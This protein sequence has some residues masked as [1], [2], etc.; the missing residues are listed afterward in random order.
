ME[1]CKLLQSPSPSQGAE[2]FS[3]SH[4]EVGRT[5][6][7]LCPLRVSAPPLAMGLPVGPGPSENSLHTTGT[8]LVLTALV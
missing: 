3:L 6:R 1:I 8:S 5:P 2:G 7:N 4:W